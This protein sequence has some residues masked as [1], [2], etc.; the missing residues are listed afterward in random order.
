M[1]ATLA[2]KM[3]PQEYLRWEQQQEDK[4]EYYDG[5]T[6]L[7]SGASGPHNTIAKNIL[8]QLTIHLEDKGYQTFISD[9]R[10]KVSSTKYV[11]PDVLLVKGEPKYADDEFY[12][13]L[14]PMVIVEVLS[15]S[16]ERRDKG[17]KFQ[18][19]RQLESFQE[20]LLVAQDC[21]RVEAFFKDKDGRWVLKEPVEEITD[22]YQFESVD[23]EIPLSAIYKN[24]TFPEETAE[25]DE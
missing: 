24:V 9:L 14:N 4:H 19:Y 10:T 18:A 15:K 12:N 11:Y 17:I 1:T 25:E 16:T 7:M 6:I 5:K 8:V 22:T 2:R 13:L 23:L 20:Y 21:C 3:S